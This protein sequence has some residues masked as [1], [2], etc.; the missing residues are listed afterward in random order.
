MDAG[1]RQQSLP[2]TPEAAFPEYIEPTAPPDA[3]ASLWTLRNLA[4]F[5]AFSLIAFFCSNLCV[6]TGYALLKPWMGWHL[7]DRALG[8]NPFFLIALQ[9]VFYLFIFLYLYLLVVINHRQPFWKAMAWRQPTLKQTLACLAAGMVLA[10]AVLLAP[11]LLP[12]AREF[13]LERLFSSPAAGYAVGSFAVLVAPLLEEL[14]FRGFLFRVFE[15]RVG[16]LFAVLVTAILFAG[17]HIPEYWGAWNHALLILVVGLVFSLARGL[18]GSL[19]PSV[20][21]HT[22]YNTCMVAGLY[23]TTQHFRTLQGM[24]A[25]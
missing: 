5:L 20:I 8:E 16:L 14:V 21:L 10:A 24:L 7:S 17:L 1:H 11:P 15:H 9:S 6:L 25:Q 2:P 22:A 13:P 18:T 12:E 3:A 23:F 19:A 4:L